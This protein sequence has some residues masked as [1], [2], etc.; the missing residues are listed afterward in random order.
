MEPSL[1]LLKRALENAPNR[2]SHESGGVEKDARVVPQLS[3][4]EDDRALMEGRVQPDELGQEIREA[5]I[6]ERYRPAWHVDDGSFENFAH[7]WE[8][9]GSSPW[10][11][12]IEQVM[13][14]VGRIEVAYLGY[15]T[16]QAGTG[17]VVGPE[18]VL[19]NRHVAEAFVHGVGR[20]LRR[21]PG[22]RAFINFLAERG[23]MGGASD[24][25][26]IER[27]AWVHPYWD[28]ALLQVPNL[29]A[30]HKPVVLAS[31]S[32]DLSKLRHVVAVGYPGF[33]PR[34]KVELQL[35]IF[36][37]P[38]GV[39]RIAPGLLM[40]ALK[41]V[42]SYGRSVN[43]LAHDC[44]TLGGNSGSA[45][46]DVETGKVIGLHFA[47]QPFI[48]N[49]TVPTWE[50]ASD[51][52]VSES[53]TLNFDKD[54]P[55]ASSAA[56]AIASAWE[57]ASQAR[58]ARSPTRLTTSDPR[59]PLGA[60]WL[61]YAND[62]LIADALQSHPQETE[63]ELFRQLGADEASELIEDLREGRDGQEWLP[64]SGVPTKTA[65]SI[66]SA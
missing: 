29:P 46:V 59:S 40:D 7:P 3:Y 14:S 56:E 44:S 47:G 66:V 2:E 16:R 36:E 1:K 43:A 8:F 23:N 15:D 35:K 27:V 64:P 32:V 5:I 65:C 21:V 48:A 54:P 49:Y 53:A 20:N 12:R 45:L 28:A 13:A 37:R 34:N 62:G 17:F 60:D 18:W 58:H 24:R 25:F 9:I 55:N 52:E 30:K 50:L 57:E 39:K 22:R 33:D 38:F 4:P 11:E 61:A 42:R 10:R 26:E 31:K 6:S 19:T 63:A 51:R 41:E